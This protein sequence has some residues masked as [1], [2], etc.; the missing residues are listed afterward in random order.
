MIWERGRII[1]YDCSVTFPY[2]WR[3]VCHRRHF[4]GRHT[5]VGTKPAGARAAGSK[6]NSYSVK[7]N[8][9]AHFN[10]RPR[11]LFTRAEALDDVV[12]DI[13]A[14]KLDGCEIKWQSFVLSIWESQPNP[15]LPVY[16]DG[17]GIII[18]FT[19]WFLFPTQPPA[20]PM[21]IWAGWVVVGGLPLA[22]APVETIG[23]KSCLP[24][25]LPSTVPIPPPP[26]PP[27]PRR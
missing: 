20:R 9:L 3:T 21:W 18:L 6:M 13:T 17:T 8:E 15:L 12:A 24:L 25:P 1:V 19:P 4:T 5:S 7:V 2:G 23:A 16:P 11:W 27:V 22:W 26:R 10:A 14:L